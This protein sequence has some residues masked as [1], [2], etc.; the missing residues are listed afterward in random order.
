[1]LEMSVLAGPT[2]TDINELPP[3]AVALEP[4]RP[5]RVVACRTLRADVDPAVEAAFDATLTAIEDDLGLPVDRVE[6][7]FGED[8]LPMLWFTI[9]SAELA[10][11]MAWCED[12]WDEFEPGLTRTLR[13][14]ARVTTSDYI[15][16]Q[17][18]RFDAAATLEALLAGDAVLVTP[19]C[20]V[21]SWEPNGPLPT[22]A[23]TVTSDPVIAMNT[24]ELNFTG[25]PGVSVPMGRSPEGVPI[26]LQIAAPRFGDRMALGLA[27][28]LES[29]RPW[30]LSAP[31]YEPFAIT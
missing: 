2:G 30:P 6:Q 28:A 14:G 29:A 9:S 3:G 11:S 24:V 7:V 27:A 26:G 20:N 10:Q 31:G 23:G 13:F 18:V 25:H 8:A 21:T 5:R 4:A 22:S 17:R 19:T 16:A 12:R 1:V 15:A